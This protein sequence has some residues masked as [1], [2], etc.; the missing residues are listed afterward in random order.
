MQSV[1]K[2]W[3]LGLDVIKGTELRQGSEPFFLCSRETRLHMW[4]LFPFSTLAFAYPMV[5]AVF[6]TQVRL[7]YRNKLRS[8][9]M[10]VVP[11]LTGEG[12]ICVL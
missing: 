2:S 8:L 3:E 1:L 6:V 12:R 7:S 9:H 11:S 5:V 4:L 10:G